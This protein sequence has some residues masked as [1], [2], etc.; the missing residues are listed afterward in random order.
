MLTLIL[1]FFKGIVFN[2]DQVSSWLYLF[3]IPSDILIILFGMSTYY[4][5]ISRDTGSQKKD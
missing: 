5:Y 2:P 3:T 1:A 4:K